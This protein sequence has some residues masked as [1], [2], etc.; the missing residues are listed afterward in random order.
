MGKPIA[1]HGQAPHTPRV[2]RRPPNRR[3]RRR[4]LVTSAAR[5]SPRSC[6]SSRAT[7]RA[8][9]RPRSAPRSSSRSSRTAT[10]SSRSPAPASRSSRASS[11]RPRRSRRPRGADPGR[12]RDRAN[13]GR[14][15][16]AELPRELEA[17]E[18]EIA[19]PHGDPRAPRAR[20]TCIPTASSPSGSAASRSARASREPRARARSRSDERLN[21]R[22][23]ALAEREAHLESLSGW[24]RTR[25]SPSSGAG[26]GRRAG[27]QG[28][29][30]G[31]LRGARAR[32]CRREGRDLEKRATE[33][34]SSSTARAPQG[35][36]STPTW[37]GSRARLPSQA[38]VAAERQSPRGVMLG[39][40]AT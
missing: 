29:R 40:M 14:R 12:A 39:C 22:E 4:P 38:V 3:H 25:S 33:L 31:Q 2:L 35:A 24:P 8:P 13:S 37:P 5:S 26:P 15:A 20:T 7:A 1:A 32:Y 11:P 9:R 36:S 23:Q 17:R 21:D 10:S 34:A 18:A 16:R 30:L 28:S 27:A 19:P 6:T